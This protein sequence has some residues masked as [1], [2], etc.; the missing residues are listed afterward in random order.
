MHHHV[1][2]IVPAGIVHRFLVFH[3]RNVPKSQVKFTSVAA[4]LGLIL[5]WDVDV[6]LTQINKYFIR[7]DKHVIVGVMLWSI[8]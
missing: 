2:I 5:L 7:N 6:G 1:S 3:L 8:L 4:I